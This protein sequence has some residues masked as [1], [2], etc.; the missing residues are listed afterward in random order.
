VFDGANW[1]ALVEASFATPQDLSKLALTEIMYNPPALGA[2]PG[3]DLEFIELKNIGLTPLD[4]SGLTFSS[5]INF[6]FTNGT[7][8]APGQFCVLARNGGAFATKYP[9]V[10]IRGTFTGQLD[11]GGET[12][13]L[14]YP[15]GGNI[16]SV[17]YD[18][19]GPWP[20]TPD[21][22]GFS[23]VPKQPGLTQAPDDG[24]K[25]RASAFVGGSPGADD[26][27]P[28]IAPIVINEVLAHTDP[29]NRDSIELYN[30]TGTNVNISGWYL[31]D[32]VNTPTKYRIPNS[33]T[34]PGGS[35]VFF[36][37]T[38]FNAGT[39]GNIA[40]L[41]SSTGEDV[42]LFSGTNGQLT[43]YSHGFSFGATFN[44]V[45][46]ERHVNSAGEESYPLEISKTFGNG[47]S[48][49]RIGP[50]IINEINY[51]PAAGGDEFVEL[52]NTSSNTVNLFDP[53][54]P[55]NTWKIGGLGY[56]FP[57]NITL[58]AEQLLLLVP[59]NP[60]AFR[61]KYGVPIGVQ[62]FGPVSGTLQDSGERLTLDFP[63]TP[64]TNMTP[65]VT[66]EAV[67]YNDKAPWP[68][69]ADGGGLSLQ[70]LSAFAYGDDPIVWTAAIPTPGRLADSADSDGD[71]M[72]DWWEMANGL[73][74]RV[75]DGNADP[76]HDGQTNLQE[77]LAGTNPNDASSNF[78][79]KVSNNAGLITLQF[80]AVSNRTY[81]VLYKDTLNDP[82]WL[83]Y[84]DI[85]ALSSNRV[86]SVLDA[87]AGDGRFYRLI[88]PQLP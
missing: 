65:Y 30:P 48:G 7:V 54:V 18:D 41:L 85:P 9:G 19:V 39:N 16:F 8:L 49:P 12:I 47:N 4:L 40:F 42:Y 71:G 79:L 14:S 21:G 68:A 67:R 59:T 35:Y 27:T 74:W 37:E 88:A 64:N 77:Y 13:T 33:T 11:N 72:P 20:V 31:T 63:D 81:S 78:K 50:V 10:P 2:I 80:L 51:N 17:T 84:S 61:I 86:E 38:Q 24:T 1:S 22:F 73:N 56:T 46:L 87:A 6:T 55:T 45:A 75:S 36:D 29:P 25:W 57:T 58:G 44:G 23:L 34:I 82:T 32:D 60:V 70:R 52:F 28:D 26:P 66:V 3:N 5:G 15:I 62:I 69:G 53:L 76:D 83:R 43:G